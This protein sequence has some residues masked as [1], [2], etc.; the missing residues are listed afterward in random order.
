MSAAAL[1]STWDAVD[2]TTQEYAAF[3]DAKSQLDGGSGFDPVWLPDFLFPF[4]RALVDWA[5]R[6]GRAALFAE[7][8]EEV[9]A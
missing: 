3:L 7:D 2:D 8:P 9:E 6:Q 5:I 4:Q 1:Q